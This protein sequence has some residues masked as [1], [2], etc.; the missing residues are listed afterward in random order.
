MGYDYI[1]K[2]DARNYTLGRQGQ[3]I[4]EIV[5][6]H[7]GI[8]GQSF[9]GIVNW[10]TSNPSCRTSAHYVVEAGKVACLVDMKNTAWHC[11][12]WYHNTISVGIECRP[13]MSV[14]DLETTAELIANIWKAV[15][16]ELPIVPHKAIVATSCPGRYMYKLDWLKQRAREHYSGRGNTETTQVADKS[17]YELAREVLAGKW[18][19]DPIRSQKLTEAGYNASLVQAEVNKLVGY[20]SLP[21]QAPKKS[22]EELAKEVLEGKWGNG[23]DRASKLANAGYDYRAVQ[24]IVNNILSSGSSNSLDKIA[25]EVIAG[26]WG[27]GSD[28]VNRLANAGYD[29]YKVQAIVNRKLS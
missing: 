1:T 19:N 3:S 23:S 27:N 12:N 20:Q 15:G 18:G 29:P 26:K 10:F 14:G 11:G 6:H 16:R 24:T 17:V 25:D 22:N 13:E 7:W 21:P 2:Y 5:L 28:R 4:K 9:Q 8:D